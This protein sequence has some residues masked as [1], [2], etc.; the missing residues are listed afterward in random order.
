M[1]KKG[2]SEVVQVVLIMAL[3]IMAITMVSKYVLILSGNLENQLSPIPDCL[4]TESEVL[5]AC[6]NSVSQ[7]IEVMVKTDGEENP[8]LKLSTGKQVFDCNTNSCST[9]QLTEGT[10]TIYLNPSNIPTDL[11]YQFDSCPS[12]TIPLTTCATP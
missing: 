3:S 12:Q 4:T 5:S 6:Y 8:Y 9:C 10:K 1:N 2:V 7:Q 11:T